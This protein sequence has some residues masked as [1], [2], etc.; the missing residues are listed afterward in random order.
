MGII[1]NL[2]HLLLIQETP[3]ETQFSVLI[4]TPA[5]IFVGRK[6]TENFP[7]IMESVIL[8]ILGFL[9]IQEEIFFS[10]KK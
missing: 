7:L 9:K 10:E 2:N 1:K 5:K 3:D 4:R 6:A 8:Y